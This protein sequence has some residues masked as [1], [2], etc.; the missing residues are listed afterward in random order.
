MDA[1]IDDIKADD[2][3]RPWED[4]L[5]TNAISCS[6]EECQKNVACQVGILHILMSSYLLVVFLYLCALISMTYGALEISW[7]L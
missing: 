1:G 4:L 3:Y 5:C 7:K 6:S 2:L